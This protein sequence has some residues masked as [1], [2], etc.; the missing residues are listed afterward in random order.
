M[1]SKGLLKRQLMKHLVVTTST[2]VQKQNLQVREPEVR[3]G[4]NKS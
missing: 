2:P 3:V 1:A 4:F